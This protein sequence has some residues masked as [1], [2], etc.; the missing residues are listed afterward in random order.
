MVSGSECGCASTLEMTGMRGVT[1]LVAASAPRSCSTAGCMNSVW[2]APAT[3]SFTVMRAYDRQ[4]TPQL[5]I[6]R[7][8][9]IAGVH[10]R[11]M[12]G[13]CYRQHDHHVRL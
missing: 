1:M 11:R 10:Q 2:N 7:S 9:S 5:C 8:C 3:A 13:T 4:I 12:E 6:L